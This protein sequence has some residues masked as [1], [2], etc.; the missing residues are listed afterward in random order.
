MRCHS[1]SSF[2]SAFQ[3]GGFPELRVVVFLHDQHPE[4]TPVYDD[5]GNLDGVARIELR[6]ELLTVGAE[7]CR[8]WM[9]VVESANQ[10]LR[11][12]EL[13]RKLPV[14]ESSS[15]IDKDVRNLLHV[16]SWVES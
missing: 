2:H 13:R 8:L 16:E 15:P 10:L 12:T 7:S 1:R 14:V 3:H 4:G 5:V 9:V 11:A 6:A